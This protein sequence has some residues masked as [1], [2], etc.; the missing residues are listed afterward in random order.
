MRYLILA[1][2]Y[3]GT[4]ATHGHLD[5]QT[6]QALEQVTASGRKVILVTGRTMESLQSVLPR[7]DLFSLIVAENGALLYYPAESKEQLLAEPPPAAL[8]QA[9]EQRQVKPLARGRVIIATEQPHETTA[10]QVI[11]E[12]GL[13][14]QVIFNKGAVMILPTGV[15]KGSGLKAALQALH[16]SPH[17]VVGV[18]DAEND[19]SFLS[20]CEYAVAVSNALPALK[21]TADYTTREAHGAGVRELI[22]HLLHDDLSSLEHNLNRHLLQL[23]QQDQEQPFTINA[24]RTSLFV[25]G[26]S[27]SGKSTMAMSLLEQLVEQQYQ[28]CLIDPE[29]DYETYQD[30]ITLGGPHRE[31]EIPEIIQAL[32]NNEQSVIVNLLGCALDDRPAFFRN[33]LPAL[34][35]MRNRLGHPHWL[36][37]DEVHHLFPPDWDS[38]A[39][40]RLHD[41]FSLILISAHPEHVARPVLA[42]AD[43]IVSVGPEASSTLQTYTRKLAEKVPARLP[44]TLEKDEGLVWLKSENRQPVRIQIRQP[45]AEH[46]RHRR[47]YAEGDLGQDISFYFRGPEDKLHLR[48]QNLNTFAQ[49]AEGVDEETWLFHLRQGDYSHWFQ[50]VIKDNELAREA[51]KI[52]KKQKISAEESRSLILEAIKKRYSV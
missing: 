28:F 38:S 16:S 11:R 4:L 23:G 15:N 46:A 6:V 12:L 36:L 24:Y 10:L 48:A 31:P 45:E 25:T 33:L 44:S 34:E 5:K 51:A 29:G 32:E 18:G 40:E 1:S 37:L 22:Q 2:D 50:E 13:E 14:Q 43:T 26:P 20:L 17:N 27:G 21:E 42:L 35:E 49:M 30:A 47:K 7:L 52:E 8:L 41:L 19:H 3:D 9:L 39:L